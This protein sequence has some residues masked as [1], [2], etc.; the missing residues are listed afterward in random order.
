MQQPNSANKIFY[1]DNIRILLTVLV[2]MHHTC[3]TYGAPGGWYFTDKSTNETALIFMTLFVATNQSFFMGFFFF[4]AALF[5]EPSYNKKGA[6]KFL[7]DRLKRLGI[8]LIFYSFIF[9]PLLNFLVYKFGHNKPGT[10]LQYLR[11][12]DDWIDF[13]VLWFVA[14]LLIFTLVYVVERKF[15]PNTPQRKRA[16]PKNITIFIFA[17]S[18]GIISYVV[19]IFFPVGWVLHPLGFQ[20]A[21]FTQ[22]I[23]LFIAGI[24]ASRNDWL[25]KIDYRKGKHWLIISIILIL[26]FPLL[27]LIKVI[28]NSPIEAFEGNGTLQSLLSAVWEQLT[29]ISIIVA[30]LGVC[31][32]RWNYSTSLLKKLARA[33]FATYILHPLTVISIALILQTWQ[34]EPAVKFLIAAPVAVIVSFIIGLLVVKLPVV[35]DII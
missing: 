16:L 11:G 5:T 21:H 32:Q 6:S 9:S 27:Y 34:I 23:A 10:F 4:L 13:G 26:S 2:I 8:P 7:S 15:Y 14:A 24:A 30:L 19:R 28:T 12:Y 17:L 22:Y 3:I 18:L 31:K 33:S 20:P 25:N 35:K 29:G 1:I